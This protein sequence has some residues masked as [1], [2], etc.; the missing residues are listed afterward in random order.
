MVLSVGVVQLE[1]RPGSAIAAVAS[2]HVEAD[3]NAQSDVA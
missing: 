1:G 2:H 3:T